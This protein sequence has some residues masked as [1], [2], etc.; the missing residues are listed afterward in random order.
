VTLPLWLVLR[1]SKFFNEE[2][3]LIWFLNYGECR[4]KNGLECD[5][6]FNAEIGILSMF[7]PV[8]NPDP[9]FSSSGKIHCSSVYIF[10][11]TDFLFRICHC[12]SPTPPSFLDGIFTNMGVQFIAIFS[13]YWTSHEKILSITFIG[14]LMH[15]IV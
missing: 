2:L 4:R 8:A 1:H 14:R 7:L 3:F 9:E 6:S 10:D 13:R 11:R 5:S 12:F 15:S